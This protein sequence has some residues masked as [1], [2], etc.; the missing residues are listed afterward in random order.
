M[1]SVEFHCKNL[2][3]VLFQVSNSKSSLITEEVLKCNIVTKTTKHCAV[4][5][6]GVECKD[7]TVRK[8]GSV[9]YK[10]C[11]QQQQKQVCFD[12]P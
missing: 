9:K 11:D 5:D 10:I 1:A 4:V 12:V 8:S 2:F 6:T 7:T 3:F